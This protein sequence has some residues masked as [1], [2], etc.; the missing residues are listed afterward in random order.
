[1]R[2]I[3]L[4]MM[5]DVSQSEW[6]TPEANTML[7][8]GLRAFAN[9]VLEVDDEAF[10]K[11]S[12]AD[13]VM[14]ERYY[15]KPSDMKWEVEF[16]YKAPGSV[17]Y[18]PLMLGPGFQYLRGEQTGRASGS[19]VLPAERNLTGQYAHAGRFFFLGWTPDANV[20]EG[21]EVA[22]VHILTMADDADIPLL[23]I[24][25][26]YGAVVNAAVLA[27]N[28]TPEDNSKLRQMLIEE[29]LKIGKYYRRSAVGAK[30]LRPDLRKHRNA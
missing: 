27:T 5:Q 8:E 2:T 1:M 13:I 16:G 19:L 12:N 21:L 17:D 20:D 9:T 24:D 4:R 26:H 3:F 22:Y 23:H 15:P 14:N 29:R 18:V 25:L 6:T 30:V 10:I 7:N 28:E 11:W